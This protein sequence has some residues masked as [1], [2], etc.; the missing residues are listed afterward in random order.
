MENWHES[1]WN[2][3]LR[4]YEK[5]KD[6]IAL[7]DIRHYTVRQSIAYIEQQTGIKIKIHTLY[8]MRSRLKAETEKRFKELVRFRY[9]HQ[10]EIMKSLEEKENLISKAWHRF[11]EATTTKDRIRCI[12]V[13]D[14]IQNSKYNIIKD[15][16]DTVVGTV[17]TNDAILSQLDRDRQSKDS[18]SVF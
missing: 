12:K 4:S 6:A 18:S 3:P 15:M 13:I 9:D 11:E 1:K 16:P 14:Q 8:M 17:K 10:H 2:V 5:I 7:S